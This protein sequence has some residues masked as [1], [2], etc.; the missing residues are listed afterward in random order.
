MLPIV[1]LGSKNVESSK[2]ETI[3]HPGSED[4]LNFGREL[5][6]EWSC[7]IRVVLVVV[8]AGNLV[9]EADVGFALVG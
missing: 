3:L 7:E 5:D 8:C 4:V 9:L 1:S 6:G 2:I